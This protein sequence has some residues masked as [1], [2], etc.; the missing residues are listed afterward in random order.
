MLH[1]INLTNN[2]FSRAD[3]ETEA[4]ILADAPFLVFYRLN[5]RD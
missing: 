3:P 5:V 1:Y 2:G 4:A